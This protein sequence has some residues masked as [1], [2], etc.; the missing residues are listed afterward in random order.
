MRAGDNDALRRFV[1][2]HPRFAASPS[3][4]R[5]DARLSDAQ[6]VIARE[7]GFAS[8]PRLKAH[9]EALGGKPDLRHPFETDLQYYRDRAAG[10][11][12]VFATGERNAVRLVRLFH[13]G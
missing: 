1:H 6:W 5:K 13:P 8:W 10:M 9:I 11:L 3:T 4:I 7:Y 12:S 2:L